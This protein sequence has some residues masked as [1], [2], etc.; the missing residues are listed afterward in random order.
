MNRKE[1]QRFVVQGSQGIIYV[2]IE[3][4]RIQL[5]ML[6]EQEENSR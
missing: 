2:S 5:G 3:I 4:K 1:N 6:G